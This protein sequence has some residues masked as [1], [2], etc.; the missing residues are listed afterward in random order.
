L[1]IPYFEM[2]DRLEAIA[3]FVAITEAGSFSG[4]AR[5]LGLSPQSVTRAIAALEARL[6][7]LLF[8]RST[9]AI[10]LTDE[11]AAY[12]EHCRPALAALADGERALQ[13]RDPEPHGLLTVTAP[14]VFGH[15][16]VAPA[17][18]ALLCDHPRLRVRL[19]LVDR[20]VSLVEEGLD[21]AVRIGALGDSALRAR[22]LGAVRKVLVAAPDYLAR[23]GAPTTPADLVAHDLVAFDGVSRLA[24]WRFSEGEPAIRLSPR[25]EVNSADAAIAA[26]EAGL[27]IAR[28]Y[29]YQV[30]DAITAG[31]LCRLLVEYE[32]PEIPVQLVYAAN[33]SAH[34]NVRAFIDCMTNR[35]AKTQL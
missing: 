25:L 21:V 26:A 32:P 18:A 19:L 23:R 31:R 12:L 35:L 5:R 13:G 22:R 28:V 24:E 16:H 11:G 2:M 7:V 33:R 20:F 3:A 9:R 17:V 14:V 1:I 34:G 15:M 30:A 29:S 27:G 4:A 6:G 8:H 10:R